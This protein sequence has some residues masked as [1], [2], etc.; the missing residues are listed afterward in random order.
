MNRPSCFLL[1]ALISLSTRVAGAER[2]S[3]A[4][5]MKRAARHPT[6]EAVDART[7][8]ARARKRQADAL[9]WPRIS[10]AL[11]VLPSLRATLV[12]GSQV[13]SVESATDYGVGD[14]RPAVSGELTIVQPLYTFGKIA[15][16]QRAADLAIAAHVASA[17]IHEANV[18]VEGA[19][20][21]EGY[22]LARDLQ[23]FLEETDHMLARSIEATEARLAA[24]A[25]DVTQ[26]DLLRLRTA[27]GPLMVG[28][29]QAAGGA[30]RAAAGL[31]A[32][33]GL[34]SGTV[35]EP[36]DERLEAITA[37]DLA[38]PKL[39]RSAL[40]RRP[41]LA[42]LASGAAAYDAMARAE[43][44][45][46]LPD[47]VAMG[48]VSFG[49]TV[50]RDA[51]ESRFVYDPAR[52]F[53]PGVGVGL[54]W[55][56]WG[57]LA[58]AR[59]DEQRARGDE[60]RKLESW[61]RT[62]LS[63]DVTNAYEELERARADLPALATAFASSKEWLVRANADYAVGMADSITLVDAVDAYLT[64]RVAQLDAAYRFNLA[65]ARLSRAIGE[66]SSGE[67]LYGGG[68]R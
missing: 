9:R 42:A 2:I 1:I 65:L 57:S 12:D 28:L 54:R 62:A 66:T 38:L 52:H 15:Y 51:V 39:I 58:G 13:D 11:G 21:Y 50:D 3:R 48:F 45:A 26:H 37:R 32:Y 18:A 61:T 4:D 7:E 47:I 22:L 53:V 35:I 30:R 31:Q 25:A 27:R 68:G 36:V 19:E 17:R 56:L 63:A 8:Q 49:Y 5:V 43:R 67:S 20:L 16:R 33:F 23:R 10:A 14:V 55:E 60:L 29:H 40:D 46:Y 44:A 6:T 24:N 64:N 41:E 34:P 59:G